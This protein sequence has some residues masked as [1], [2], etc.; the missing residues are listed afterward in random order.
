MPN[1]RYTEVEMIGTLKR[2]EAWRQAKHGVP[3]V[4]VSNHATR[5]RIYRVENLNFVTW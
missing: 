3:E 1:S 4:G 2:L 5:S